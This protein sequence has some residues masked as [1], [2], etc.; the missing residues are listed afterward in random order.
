MA[1]AIAGLPG[2]EQLTL[3]PLT[4]S[5]IR[6]LLTQSFLVDESQIRTFAAFLHSRT[7]GNPFFVEE[8]IKTL[9][10][11]GTLHQIDDRWVGWD[12]RGHRCSLD[13]SGSPPRARERAD[14]ARA[15]CCRPGFGRWLAGVA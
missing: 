6:E 8:M 2:S 4:E 11:R 9:I 12:R 14:A 3:A 7:L 10:Q 1:K 5:D 15:E 13:H